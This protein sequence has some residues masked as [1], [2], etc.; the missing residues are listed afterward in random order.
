MKIC[1]DEKGEYL[2][3][4]LQEK[5]LKI[6]QSTVNNMSLKRLQ[7]AAASFLLLCQKLQ[8]STAEVAE[9]LESEVQK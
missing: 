8:L 2:N 1:K 9:I 5:T 3:S 7:I 6:V 4:N